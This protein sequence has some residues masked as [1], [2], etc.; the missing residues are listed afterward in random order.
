MTITISQDFSG[1]TA[2]VFDLDNTLYP[3]QARL[4]D[5]IEDLMHRYVMRE[6]HLSKSD[7]SHLRKR[8]WKEHGTTLNGLMQN[9]GIHPDPFLDEVHDIDLSHLTEDERLGAAIAALP[10]RKIVYTNGSRRHG[11]RVTEARG[12]NGVFDAIFGIE[13]AG[14]V[15][16]PKA[17]AF[18]KV[19]AKAAIAPI[20]AAM[21]ED[22]AR[23]LMVPF[24]WGMKTVLVGPAEDA[25]HAPDQTEHLAAFLEALM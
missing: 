19:F 4:F 15:P 8:Y 25:P 17:G 24:E 11:Q 20:G 18:A 5:Q 9:H 12:L 13:D 23:N 21:F 2:W 6:L 10:G 3:P 16:K 14:Y 7:A 1:V 22:D